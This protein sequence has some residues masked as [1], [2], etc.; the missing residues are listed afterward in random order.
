VF[1]GDA[2]IDRPPFGYPIE[3]AEMRSA[4]RDLDRLL[5]REEKDQLV[6]YLAFHPDA[7]AI[8]PETGGI[9]KLR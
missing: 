5:T 4:S 6:D 8:I 1:A 9:R 7:G 3:I 2:P